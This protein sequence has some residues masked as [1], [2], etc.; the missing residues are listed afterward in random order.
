MTYFQQ[1][2]AYKL[3][4]KYFWYKRYHGST[5]VK[6]EDN[7]ASANH[8]RKGNLTELSASQAQSILNDEVDTYNSENKYL[9]GENSI[10]ATKPTLE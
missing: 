2:R 4:G 9:L 8:I 3:K 5:I 7:D 10:Q 6:V 1:T